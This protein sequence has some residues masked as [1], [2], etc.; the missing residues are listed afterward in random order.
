MV[1]HT[2]PNSQHEYEL[3]ELKRISKSKLQKG[4]KTT[5]TRKQKN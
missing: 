2:I 1:Y 4:H 3:Q 5:M